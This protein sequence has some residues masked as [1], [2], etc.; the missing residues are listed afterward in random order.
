MTAGSNQH[1]D[2]KLIASEA[3]S[4]WN[5]LLPMWLFGGKLD[6]YE[7]KALNPTRSDSK[8]GSFSVNVRTGAWG[9]FATGD[10]GGDLIALYAYLHGIDQLKAAKEV[11][12]MV[13]VRVESHQTY[14]NQRSAHQSD[15]E[16]SEV[17]SKP[18]E[19]SSLDHRK[20]PWV[21][22][23]P[24]PDHAPVP[25]VA[26]YARGRPEVV[27][28]YR[29][30]VG[31]VNG[32]IY[33]FITS[34]GG[35]ETLPVSFCVNRDD[36]KEDWRFMSFPEPRPL[37]RLDH[38]SRANVP[39]LLVEGE[40]CA[41]VAADLLSDD[42]D[43]VTWPG[44]S[45][46][47]SKADWSHLVGRKVV[48][49]A[50]CDAIRRKLTKEEVSAGVDPDSVPFLP[51]ADQPGMRAMREIHKILLGID[52]NI[53]FQF[54]D[55]PKPGEKPHGWDIAD[56]V[57]DGLVGVALV[58]F[59]R[60]VRKPPKAKRK[61]PG[62]VNR[63]AGG[64]L[65]NKDYKIVPCLANIYDILR[66]DPRWDGVLAFNEFSYVINKLKAPP[67]DH[68]IVGEWE[69]NDDVQA[70]MW[71]TRE[72]G[73]APTPAQVGEAVEALARANGF[74]PVR[75]YLDSLTWDGVSRVDDWIT[76][77]IGAAKND[78]VMRVSRWFL[79]GMV[80]RVM[81]PGVKF[82]CCL[83]LEG[84]QGRRKSAMLRVLAGEWFGDTDLDLHNK[85]SMNS[86]RGKWLYEFAELGSLARAEATKQKSFLSRQVD[87][88]RPPYGRRDIRSPRQLVFGGTTNDWAWN[89]D[90]TGGRRFWPIECQSDIDCDGLASVRDQLFA[91][92]YDL[93]KQ[94]KRFWP[95][96]D[97]QKHIFD[98]EQMKRHQPD[99]FTEILEGFVKQQF[100]LFRMVDAAEYLKV[101]AA[102]LT[103]D[104]QTRIGKALTSL[105]CVRV[106]KRKSA[107]RFWYQP[108][109]QGGTGDNVDSVDGGGNGIPF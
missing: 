70:S 81:Q 102:R 46:A 22:V 67:Y 88:F 24:V 40:K 39:V 4:R 31:R 9:D 21:P 86:I 19:K 97:E 50:D 69:A 55:I 57:L 14:V 74:H 83:V 43:V 101:D 94:G 27:Y 79:M 61:E 109:S 11:A 30:F 89:K 76:D 35:K 60:N 15:V 20:S 105:G 62:E 91:E 87:E 45:K 103:R 77:Y 17:P 28:T 36:G 75:D 48:A 65:L 26:H 51:E 16:P 54:V 1:V 3:L 23:M 64:L 104:I 7:F 78:Y 66:S 90:E 85:D 108:P 106:E 44:G 72:Y 92:A 47:V 98:A 80:A 107:V 5:Q 41:D 38:L 49:W 68:S 52:P 8:V 73:F 29:D 95:N 13:G 71:L 58:N 99:G 84:T 18:Q 53:D 10:K 12:A 100:D 6:G 33:R 37:Y 59:I 96:S 63:S 34:D 2:F 93:Y 32:Y 42:F 25:P 82:D 56:A